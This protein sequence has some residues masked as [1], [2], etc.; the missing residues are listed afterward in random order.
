MMKTRKFFIVSITFMLVFVFLHI[1]SNPD[2]LNDKE[3]HKMKSIFDET[4]VQ[5]IGRYI[6]DVPSFFVNTQHSAVMI[7]EYR[8]GTQRM[9]LPAFEQMIRLREDELKK[10]EAIDPRDRPFLKKS[11][12]LSDELNGVIFD[13]N[14]GVSIPGYGRTLEAYLYHGGVAFTITKKFDDLSDEKYSQD[15]AEYLKAGVSDEF[16]TLASTQINEIK[17]MLKT[18]RGRLDTD[19]LKTAGSCMPDGFISDNVNTKERMSLVYDT[20]FNI[21]FSIMTNNFLR[22][23][24]SL[25]D[26]TS[27]VRS[28]LSK[29]NGVV[30]KHES[31]II[32]GIKVDELL[33][34][35]DKSNGP[36]KLYQFMLVANEKNADFYN[37]IISVSLNNYSPDE[38]L[39]SEAQVID[40]WNRITRT[41]RIRPGAF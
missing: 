30:I 27:G 23:K 20:G 39:L 6:F 40:L 10:T 5:C 21:D 29:I 9:Y 25:L 22:E 35:G 31:S 33:T 38:S 37:P 26:R 18:L 2:G 13:R 8:L 1:Y 3:K 24:D 28:I 16:F 15:K 19:L 41:I 14:E 4:K 34:V 17:K 7:N 11:I 36:G 12:V 32:N